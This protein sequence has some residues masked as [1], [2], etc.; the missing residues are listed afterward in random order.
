MRVDAAHQRLIGRATI[1]AA[2]CLLAFTLGGC[3]VP[4]HYIARVKIERDGSYKFYAEGTAL[5]PVV[6]NALRTMPTEEKGAKLKPEELQKRRDGLLAPLL[7]DIAKA[8]G[9]TRVENMVS[10]GDGRIRFSLGGLWR[11]DTT[12]LIFRELLVPLAYAVGQ[13]GTL[14]IRVKD[15]PPSREARALGMQVTGDVSVSVAEGVEVLEHN[16][17]K[18]PTSPTGAYRWHIDADTKE[19]PYLRIRLPAAASVSQST[20]QQTQKKL[21]H[22]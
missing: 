1:A 4:E 13:D 12:F 22:H 19:A 11:M 16:A 18:A 21:A 15:A 8:K 7:A 10:I 9:D 6:W 17:L 14:R 3:F 2:L 20:S 5:D